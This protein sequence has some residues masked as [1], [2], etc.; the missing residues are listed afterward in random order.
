MYVHNILTHLKSLNITN[1]FSTC[2]NDQNRISLEFEMD[3][4]VFVV[5]C[6]NNKY[7]SV[8]PFTKNVHMSVNN[9]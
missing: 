2:R 6:V 9:I 5:L 4:V 1:D 7:I 3:Y 8:C